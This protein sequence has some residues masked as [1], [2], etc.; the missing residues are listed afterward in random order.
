VKLLSVIGAGLGRTGTTSLHEALQKLGYNSLHFDEERLNDILDGS[1]K[2]PSFRRYDDVDAVSDVPA[3][4]FYHE[5]MEAYPEARVILTVRDV[6]AWWK[7]IERLFTHTT[8]VSVHPPLVR[9][10]AGKLGLEWLLGREPEH[11]VFLRNLRNCAYGSPIPI[12]SMYKRAYWQHNQAVMA[13]VPPE[14]L[15]IM[16]IAAGDG[17]DKLCGFLGV[18]TPAIPFPCTNQTHP[19]AAAP[20]APRPATSEPRQHGNDIQSLG[21]NVLGLA[22]SMSG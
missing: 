7:S 1:A 9:Q 19:T 11:T 3:A 4:L 22:A 2:Q 12:E 17:W 6:D 20:P 15:L 10:I 13:R 14:R 5:L 8:P 21:R 18:P 16:D